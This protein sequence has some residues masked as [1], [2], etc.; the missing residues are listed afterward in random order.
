MAEQRFQL[1]AEHDTVPGA[2]VKQRLYPEPVAA[3]GEPPRVP[4]PQGEGVNPVQPLECARPP[5]QIG[6]QQ[7]LG[8]GMPLKGM[9][10]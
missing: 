9:P 10:F 8:I 6:V 4:F 7:H 3:Q 5:F 1:G 2:A